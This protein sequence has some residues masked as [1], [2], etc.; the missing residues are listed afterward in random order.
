MPTGLP[1][2]QDTF[3]GHSDLETTL[4]TYTHAIP[5]SQRR[6]VERVAGVLN[7]DGPKPALEA[8]PEGLIN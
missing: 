3:L 7:L 5:E 4:G 1:V 2:A 6:A 8:S